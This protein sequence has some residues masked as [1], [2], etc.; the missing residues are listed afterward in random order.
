MTPVFKDPETWHLDSNQ[1]PVPLSAEEHAYLYCVPRFW[2]TYSKIKI[3]NDKFRTESTDTAKQ[4]AHRFVKAF[5]TRPDTQLL[6]EDPTAVIQEDRYGILTRV[7]EVKFD[8]QGFKPDE[9]HVLL[10]V[11]WY[12]LNAQLVDQVSKNIFVLT[13]ARMEEAII[14][15]EDIHCQ[16]AI[17][18]VPFPASR[19]A[20]FNTQLVRSRGFDQRVLDNPNSVAVI[21]DKTADFF[22]DTSDETRDDTG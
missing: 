20:R 5:F 16:V 10:S 9:T 17:V 8:F 4:T 6:Q 18:P 21:F 2:M 1:H 11:K 19:L 14:S 3:G 7:M 15:A 12:P 13:N 22:K